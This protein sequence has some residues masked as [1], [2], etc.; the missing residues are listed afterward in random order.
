MERTIIEKDYRLFVRGDKMSRMRVT[1]KRIDRR[2]R[3]RRWRQ[4]R[5]LYRGMDSSMEALRNS[6]MYRKIAEMHS[7]ILYDTNAM[8]FGKKDRT[9]MGKKRFF[10]TVLLERLP[11]QF[12]ETIPVITAL[13]QENEVCKAM[14]RQ[15]RT[16][17][18]R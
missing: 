6:R 5:E 10:G 7:G 15:P 9:K 12:L 8:R 18:D 4:R 13:A 16:K 2:H 17:I 1:L 3:L 14:A 11:D